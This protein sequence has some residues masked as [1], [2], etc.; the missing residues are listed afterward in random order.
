MSCT[1]HDKH[2][3]TERSHSG[4]R[5]LGQERAE[6]AEQQPADGAS[7]QGRTTVDGSLQ[8]PV[9]ISLAPTTAGGR[10]AEHRVRRSGQYL[11][12]D[13]GRDRCDD[14]ASKQHSGGCLGSAKES[15]CK[16]GRGSAAESAREDK[17]TRPRFGFRKRE[18][19][20]AIAIVG[21]GTAGTRCHGL[22]I[23]TVKISIASRRSSHCG[24]HRRS[25]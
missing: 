24:G 11:L 13:G 17:R 8:P 21:R 4:S 6:P 18:V 15:N 25:A 5:L 20:R 9:E 12:E 3:S 1:G 23:A 7:Q 10:D 14:C 22:T 16:A 19:E 2:Q